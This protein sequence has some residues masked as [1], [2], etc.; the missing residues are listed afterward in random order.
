MR[1]HR[2]DLQCDVE[3]GGLGA[4]SEPGRVVAQ[5]LVGPDMDQKRRQAREI[6]VKR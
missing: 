1:H 4:L 6:A 2:P 3:A 5:H